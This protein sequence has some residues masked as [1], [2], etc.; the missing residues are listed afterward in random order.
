MVT[1]ERVAA[2]GTDLLVMNRRFGLGSI[3][4]PFLAPGIK[5]NV[6]SK[7]WV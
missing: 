4:G 6:C 1:A 2:I 5:S 7:F 3:A